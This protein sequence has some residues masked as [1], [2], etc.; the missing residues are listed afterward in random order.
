MGGQ[1]FKG[2]DQRSRRLGP[3][4]TPTGDSVPAHEACGTVLA[5]IAV[6]KQVPRYKSS[7]VRS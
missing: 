1:R 4:D 7:S 2:I 3:Y 5:G 6:H